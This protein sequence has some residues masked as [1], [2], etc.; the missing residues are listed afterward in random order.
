MVIL[1]KL[2]TVF[3]FV[4]SI[5]LLGFAGQTAFS[6]SNPKS[7]AGSYDFYE[8]T[9]PHANWVYDVRVYEE[10]GY[11]YAD[12]NIDGF[13]TM[14]RLK[15]KVQGNSKSI[16][17]VFD[18]YLPNNMFELYKKGDILFTLKKEGNM[19]LTYWGKLEAMLSDNQKSGKV[20]FI[21][22]H[23]PDKT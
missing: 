4:F 17:L 2:K 1:M 7:W 6:S 3:L 11:Y 5:V 9:P 23:K 13:Q 8:F 18:S 16:D 14:T 21:K 10:G 20:Y 12:V 19:I 22:K 15:A